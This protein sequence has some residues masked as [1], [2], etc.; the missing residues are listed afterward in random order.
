MWRIK[1]A[2]LC[3]GVAQDARGVLTLV[4]FEAPALILSPMPAQA[5]P[6]LVM[7]LETDDLAGD[8]GDSWATQMTV[9]SQV[10]A[11]DG[12]TV[13]LTEA[14]QE[15][16]HDRPMN[17]YLPRRIQQILQM[18]FNV[19]KPGRYV[20]SSD[21]RFEGSSDREPVALSFETSL[22]ILDLDSAGMVVNR[23]G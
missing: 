4:G 7:M 14:R 11:P 15:L 21:L 6:V 23:A 9:R 17:P 10:T 2:A 5:S 18:A 3:E 20:V 16:T 22:M 19:P 13:F 8:G 12:T 1:S